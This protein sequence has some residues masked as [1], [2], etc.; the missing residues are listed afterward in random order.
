ML[1]RNELFREHLQRE[2][3][4]RTRRNPRFSMRAFGQLLKLEPS[5]LSQILRGTRPLTD[6]MCE[7][8]SEKLELSP[9]EAQELM[10]INLANV[11]GGKTYHTLDT[12][13][14][15]A[16]S[17][18]YHYAILEL[19]RVNHFKSDEKWVAR[20]LGVTVHEVRAAV[21]RLQR[22]DF[23]EIDSKGRWHDRMGD[24]VNKGNE[25]THAAFKKYE[26][27]LLQKAI[28]AID[29]TPYEQ[30]VHSSMTF[31]TAVKNVPLAKKRIVQFI[32]QLTAELSA[33]P[34]KD[35]VYYLGVSLFPITKAKENV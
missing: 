32:K 29:N 1:T 18:W 14:F 20:V 3:I 35:E 6:R 25:V 2:L 10:S 26:K 30:R 33:S 23:L 4:E 27:Q 28:E 34:S 7:R 15:H 16:I 11:S 17:D 22:L 9:A 21:E 31:P 24:A 13:L 19:T 5:A 12:D 8:L